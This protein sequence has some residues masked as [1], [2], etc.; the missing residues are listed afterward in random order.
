MVGREERSA[1]DSADKSPQSDQSF[2]SAPLIKVREFFPESFV[3]YDIIETDSSGAAKLALTVPDSITSWSTH[4]IAMS[5]EKG[6]GL[7][8][9]NDISLTVFQPFFVDVQLPTICTRGEIL[10]LMIV[11][12][13]YL[14]EKLTI[15]IQLDN[16]KSEFTLYSND[17][18]STSTTNQISLTINSEGIQSYNFYIQPKKIGMIDIQVSGKRSSPST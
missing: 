2:Q 8:S 12:H 15:Q 16:S 7:T 3:A 1:A 9:K 13:N 18:I 11:V 14:S 4:A 6:L 10:S 5:K 17:Q